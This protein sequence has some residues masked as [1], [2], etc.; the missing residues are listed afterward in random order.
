ME[1]Y[2]S[3]WFACLFVVGLLI[4]TACSSL[5]KSSQSDVK[6]SI[7]SSIVGLA[8]TNNKSTLKET[9]YKSTGP[10]DTN[11]YYYD[12]SGKR[13]AYPE[14]TEIA[15]E[16]VTYSGEATIQ[17]TSTGTIDDS[18]IDSSDAVISLVDGDGYYTDE[19]VLKATTLDNDWSNGQTTYTLSEGDLEWSL[20][21]YVVS[22]SNSGKE[23]SAFGGDG[24]GVYTFNLQVSGL[25]YDG[26]EVDAQT[27]KVKV[28][29]YGRDATDMAEQYNDLEDIVATESSSGKTPSNTI[30]W[31]W[32]GS[33]DKPNL[34]DNNADNIYITWSKED[35]EMDLSADAV[36][37]TLTSE[38]GDSLTLSDDDYQVFN[39]DNETQIAL[40]YRNWASTPVYTEMTISVKT[41][42]DTISQTYDIASVYV[43]MVQSG[44]GATTV[45]GTVTAYSYY[46]IANL[47][48]VNQVMNDATYTLVSDDGQYYVENEDGTSYLT[49]DESSATIFDASGED[50]MNQALLGNVAVMTSRINQTITKTIDHSEIT[51]TK[52]Y[53]TSNI[54]KSYQEMREAGLEAASGYV[55]PED[56]QGSSMWAWQDKFQYGWT[57]DDGPVTTLP[58]YAY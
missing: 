39:H 26:E 22:D 34:A 47:D 48:S 45:D 51:F 18:K 6:V 37:I 30:Q 13:V 19:L 36:T 20:G 50:E 32:K 10:G 11:I 46:G 29:I 31:T 9:V 44:G 3:Y 38:Y 17:L 55:F 53:D 2:R 4:L 24:N 23:W 25:K 5:A 21:D 16:K 35:G 56:S 57:P 49:S 7:T 8:D 12:E 33:G 41:E 27:F 52:K 15:G 58:T 28:Y 43:N 54:N 14:G 40:I 1:K 42:G